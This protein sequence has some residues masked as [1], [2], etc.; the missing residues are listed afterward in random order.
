MIHFS[1]E[2]VC[3]IVL[4]LSKKSRNL[5]MEMDESPVVVKIPIL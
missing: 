2:L 3:F 1:D 4:I 5:F